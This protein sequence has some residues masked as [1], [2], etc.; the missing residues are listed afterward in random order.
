[1]AGFGVLLIRVFLLGRIPE[2]GTEIASVDLVYSPQGFAKFLIIHNFG[3]GVREI[4]DFLHG[5][6]SSELYHMRSYWLLQ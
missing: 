1:M 2:E 4:G 6:N 3:V 5:P